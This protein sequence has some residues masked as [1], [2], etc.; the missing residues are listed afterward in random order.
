MKKQLHKL[1][2]QAFCILLI[3]TLQL[4]PGVL[5]AQTK[6]VSGTITGTANELI[7]GAT[8]TVKQTKK[9]TAT[10]ASGKFS[11]EADAGDYLYRV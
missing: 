11:I 8:I 1:L 2:L 5:K 6:T 4:L 10:D 7:S 3:A 9:A